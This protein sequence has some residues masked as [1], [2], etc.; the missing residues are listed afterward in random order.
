M[1]DHY[2]NQLFRREEVIESTLAT[3]EF[4]RLALFPGELLVDSQYRIW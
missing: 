4:G 3:K 2:P 1:D